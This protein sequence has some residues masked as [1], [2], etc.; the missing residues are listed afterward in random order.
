[1]KLAF[2]LYKYFPYGG[3]QRNMLAIAHEAVARGHQVSVFCT[4]WDTAVPA[5]IE[6]VVIS[7]RGWTNATRMEGFAI[8]AERALAA[9][10]IDLVVGFNKL[11]GLDLYYAADTCFAWKAC[12]RK[13]PLSRLTLR[14]RTYL[15]FERRVFGADLAT[16]ILEVSMLERPRFIEFYQTP[17]ARFHPLPPGIA[18]NRAEPDNFAE[19]RA[20]MRR[21]LNASDNECLLL[22]LGSGFKR[23]GVDRCIAA[24]G[25]LRRTG[26]LNARLLVVGEGNPRP[27]LRQA[28]ALGVADSVRFLGGRNEVPDFLQAA[29]VLLHPAY[30]ENTGNVLL[31]AMIAGLPVVATA[32]CGYAHYVTNADMGRV[33]TAPVQLPA[34]VRAIAEIAAVPRNVWRERGRVLASDNTIYARPQ[35]AVDIIEAVAAKRRGEWKTNP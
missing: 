32:V 13:G 6:L 11:P 16:E 5:G 25:E 3:L 7:R 20:A 10:D 27:F 15:E 35:V 21:Q 2:L 28:S 18:R 23:K 1:M 24:L 26:A 8:D 30:E 22:A 12:Y 14:S 31:E 9:R 29:D 33:I 19:L 4:A 17:T 34:L